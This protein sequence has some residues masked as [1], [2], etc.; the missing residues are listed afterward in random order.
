MFNGL[1]RAVSEE[2]SGER[3]LGHVC[4]ISRFHRIQASPGFRRA[5]GY[6]V[7]TMLETSDGARVIHY[8]AEDGVRFWRFPSFE[9]W[10][11]KR[12][13]LKVM[14]PGALAGKRADFEVCPISLIQRSASTPRGGVVAD[15][16]Y[17]GS[18]ESPEDYKRARGKIAIVDSYAPHTVYDAAVRAGVRGIIIYRQKPLEPVRI[19]SGLQGI[20]PYCS[21]WWDEKDLFGFVL[22]PEDGERLVS[23]LRSPAARKH[24]VRAWAVVEGERYPGTME[25]VTSLIPGR[26]A[27]E[28]VLVAH[29]CHPKPSAGDNAS[30]VAALLEV[31]RT[32]SELIRVGRLPQPRY[33][34]RF[35]L[36]P[37]IT[38]TFAYLDRESKEARN[39]LMG[40]NLDMV[41]QKQDVTGSTLCI[42]KPPMAAA[43]FG[44]YLLA[45][46]ARS[47][48]SMASN[49][50]N[51]ALLPLARWT[52][53]PFSGGSDH[54][55]LS[56]PT[57]GVP[58]PMLIQW[59]DK[60]YHTSGDLPENV[61]ADLL[62]KIVAI[63]G[64][65][66]YLCALADAPALLRVAAL[67]GRGLR[68]EY[69]DAM[70]ALQDSPAA[71]WITPG[72][73]ARVLG[74][75]AGRALKSVAKMAPESAKLRR[76]V[77]KEIAAVRDCLRREAALARR[78]P[79][80]SRDG[81]RA[82]HDRQMRD[83]DRIIVERLIPGPVDPRGL[84]RTL[85]PSK[86]ARFLGR[87]TKQA[88]AL[89]V[90]TAALY[91]ADGRRSIAEIARLVAAEI[92]HTDP[93][94][95]KF[96]FG[97]LR[98]AKIVRYKP[99]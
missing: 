41:G 72:Y 91:W 68:K 30:G 8:P 52:E 80:K 5:A 56:D 78:R 99:L 51:T 38:G 76:A 58:T 9:E 42:E 61:S 94:F 54:A 93:G 21:F 39:L 1:V 7:D 55:V 22:T 63:A 12:A 25:V 79:G 31:H 6:C 64:T 92:G 59:P 67:T 19:G 57:V 17:A 53:M 20:R 45:E 46:L 2:A 14:A 71:D 47:E 37:E 82:A 10:N 66:I 75:A 65:Y 33:G 23:Y 28:I 88:G 60:Y 95:L 49:P 62:G 35:L 32:L 77:E 48:L 89:M 74:A 86:R 97:L 29:L 85:T 16:V 18:G 40:L 70:A 27:R 50:G 13:I 26:E 96:Y 87:V 44:P 24:P 3:A 81:K 11:C 69:I 90:G 36:V 98:D 34:I 73:K 84:M 43:S 15:I 4:S 83:L